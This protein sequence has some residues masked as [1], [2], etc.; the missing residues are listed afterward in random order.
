MRILIHD[1]RT[2]GEVQEDFNKV[3]PFLKLEFFSNTAHL[4]AAHSPKLIRDPAAK[5]GECRCVR[6]QG[7]LILS[8]EM[9]VKTLIEKLNNRF[10]L[11]VRVLR[12]SGKSWINTT[13]TESWTLGEQ[14][15]H[16][17]SL[18]GSHQAAE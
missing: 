7:E 16:G 3:Y 4:G 6:T 5:L 18:S 15:S 13:L 10:G 1:K 12:K 2:I 14:N 9:T 11:F 17:E 8:N